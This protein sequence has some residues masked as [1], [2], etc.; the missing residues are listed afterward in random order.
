MSEIFTIKQHDAQLG[1]TTTV[2][3]VE[4]KIRIGKQY[5]ASEF[6]K[7][8]AEMRADTAGEQWGELRHVGFIPM[9]ELSKFYRQDGGFDHKRCM[10][11]LKRNPALVT[12]DKALK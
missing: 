1:I 2:E 6:L 9:A 5:D 8:A 3:S 12:F 10:A 11:W 7:V 4:G